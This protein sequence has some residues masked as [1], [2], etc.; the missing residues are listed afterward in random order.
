[1]SGADIKKI[2]EALGLS[3]QRFGQLLGVHWVTVSRWE[4]GELRPSAYQEQLISTF[5]KAARREK[6]VGSKASDELVA[7]GVAAALLLL[8]IAAMGKK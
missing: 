6:D 8:L 3:Q 4:R 2:R 7:A 5:R 1:M